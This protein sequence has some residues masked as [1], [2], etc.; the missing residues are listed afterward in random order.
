MYSPMPP[1]QTQIALQEIIASNGS[2]QGITRHIHRAQKLKFK[3]LPQQELR[4]LF[5]TSH[6]PNSNDLEIC[7]QIIGMSQ[8]LGPTR[9]S[10]AKRHNAGMAQE[11]P[12]AYIAT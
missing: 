12:K 8:D 7:C 10:Y 4:S 3:T 5:S 1:Y 9:C 2:P 11:V 6:W